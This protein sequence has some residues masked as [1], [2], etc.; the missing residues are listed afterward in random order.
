MKHTGVK[1]YQC[2]LCDQTFSSEQNKKRHIKNVHD[3]L[4]IKITNTTEEIPKSES[5]QNPV[6]KSKIATEE[7]Q[8]KNCAIEDTRVKQSRIIKSEK[9]QP[10][11]N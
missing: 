3:K 9:Y 4:D 8:G 6:S 11:P 1:L 10:I 2:H 5:N 7:V